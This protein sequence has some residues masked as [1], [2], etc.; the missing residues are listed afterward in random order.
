MKHTKTLLLSLAVVTIGSL[1]LPAAGTR[2]STGANQ[3]LPQFEVASIKPNKSGDGRVMISMQPGGRFTAT[4]VPLKFLIRNAYQLQDFQIVGGPDW[5]SSER[6]DVVAKAEASDQGDPFRGAKPGEPSRGQL[7]L[8]ALLAERFKLEAHNE[9]REMPIFALVTA[10]SDGKLGPELQKSS[11]DCEA[12]RSDGPGRGRGAVP[13]PGPPQPGERPV[14]GIRIAPGN[15]S[16]GGSTL[17]QFASSIGSFVGRIVVDRT[18]LT[19][20][21]DFNLTWTPDQVGSRPPGAPDPLVNGVPIDPNGPSIFTAVQEQLGLKLDSQKGPV[22][23]L[24]IDRVE[25]P[26]ED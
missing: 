2:Q 9:N 8:R 20:M 3:T 22:A 4:N 19:G 6:F 5:I 1:T 23:V 15:M 10:R 13:P 7:M 18:G 21:Y 16:V 25:H 17:A 14:C 11:T 26:V 12:A 24:V